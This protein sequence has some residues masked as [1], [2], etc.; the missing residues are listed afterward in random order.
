M[1]REDDFKALMIA[2]VPLMAVLT[3]GVFTA[4]SVGRDGITRKSAP[5]AYDTDGFLKP[6]AMVS[7]RGD[8]P[9]GQ[10]SDEVEQADSTVQIVE[11]YFYQDSG[12]AATSAAR[13]RTRVVLRGKSLS[14][15]FPL[16]I[17]NV[18]TRMR[19]DGALKG[20]SMERQ[21]WQ[22]NSVIQ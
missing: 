8:I 10:M 16:Q 14:N 19:D 22:V 1:A 3:G 17:V 15:S 12:Y 6:C 2:D 18:L 11:I 5:G 21:D 20:A 7:E 9:D 13:A 4:G